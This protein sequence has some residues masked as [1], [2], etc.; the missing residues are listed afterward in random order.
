MISYSGNK[1]DVA[2][3]NLH[4]RS[5]NKGISDAIQDIITGIKD[6][7]ENLPNI[8]I[9]KIIKSIQDNFGVLI[10]SIWTLISDPR[11]SFDN[12]SQQLNYIAAIKGYDTP[13]MSYEKSIA[14]VDGYYYTVLALGIAVSELSSSGLNKITQALKGAKI[15][16]AINKA[17]SDS[18]IKKLIDEFKKTK[19]S[20]K[21][22]EVGLEAGKYYLKDNA[23]EE[24]WLPEYKP[25]A[26]GFDGIVK[27]D[28]YYYISEFKTNSS[29]LGN[30]EDGIQMGKNWVEI[31]INNMKNS[32][33][34][35]EQEMGYL[36]DNSRKSGSLR[37]LIVKTEFE[38]KI[39]DIRFDKT[40]INKL[41]LPVQ[42]LDDVIE[43]VQY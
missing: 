37:G 30:T 15:L 42:K 18:K 28:D 25:G 4:P 7:I 32:S 1:G 8:T 3:T 12:I 17:N 9:E 38:D 10:S 31:R 40:N 26:H 16:N 21:A 5:F 34:P 43:F 2:R 39:S 36:L 27:K 41:G 19:D 13:V 6:D 11:Q 29:Q 22:G 20:N 14:Y 23:F 33:V 24:I 35:K